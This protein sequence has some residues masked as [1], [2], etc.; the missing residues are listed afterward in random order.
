MNLTPDTRIVGHI[1]IVNT[2]RGTY[3]VHAADCGDV[4]REIKRTRGDL[5]DDLA[6]GT[7]L[8]DYAIVNFGD[9]A[10]D[11]HEPG[12]PEHVEACWDEIGGNLQLLPC[13]QRHLRNA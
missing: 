8:G 5:W 3:R 9:I 2:T 7:T 10:S 13:A 4:T 6:I 12:T 1:V 11:Q